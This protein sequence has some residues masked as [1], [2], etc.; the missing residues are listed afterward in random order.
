M[1][2]G[3]AIGAAVAIVLSSVVGVTAWLWL[4]DDAP[5]AA[6]LP[7][8]PTTTGA[9]V[10][11]P[12]SGSDEPGAA[13]TAVPATDLAAAL[14]PDGTWTVVAMPDRFAGYRIDERYAGETITRTAV[15]RTTAVTGTMSIGDGT[16][17]PVRIDADVSSLASDQGERDEVLRTEGL[18]TQRF[19]TASFELTDALKLGR[20][21]TVGEERTFT[22]TGNLTLHGV[23]RPVSIALQARWNGDTIDVAGSL[24]IRLADF[25]IDPP[26]VPGLVTVAGDGVLE[27][28]LTFGRS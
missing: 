2:R 18:E 12:G 19:P 14:T 13:T 28:V 7:D 6:D 22:A 15:G 10:L 8:S 17:G 3:L 16:I 1:R 23:T 5:I 4:G 26:S 24:P 9:A 27:F 20:P 11:G 25:D 21:A